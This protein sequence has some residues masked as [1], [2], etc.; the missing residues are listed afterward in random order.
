M[1]SGLLASFSTRW[2]MYYSTYFWSTVHVFFPYTI[3]IYEVKHQTSNFA[4]ESSKYLI[5]W[6]HWLLHFKKLFAPVKW[7]QK[8]ALRLWTH[9]G[10]RRCKGMENLLGVDQVI[11]MHLKRELGLL[12]I[13]LMKEIHKSP[14]N[15]KIT[16]WLYLEQHGHLGDNCW[17]YLAVF[18]TAFYSLAWGSC[19]QLLPEVGTWARKTSSLHGSDCS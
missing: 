18:V 3:L 6:W 17:V 12:F 14:L 16:Q 11:H 2:N 19:H 10:C 5:W 9:F 7:V 15:T 13:Y 1:G 8:D 4:S